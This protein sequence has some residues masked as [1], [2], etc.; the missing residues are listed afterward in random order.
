MLWS[1]KV[2]TPVDLAPAAMQEIRAESIWKGPG[3]VV[4]FRKPTR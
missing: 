3:W 2:A 1:E 4:E